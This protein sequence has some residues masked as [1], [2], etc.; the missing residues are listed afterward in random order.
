MREKNSRKLGS[1]ADEEKSASITLSYLVLYQA[2][3][4]IFGAAGKGLA[5]WRISD[6]KNYEQ[7]RKEESV[8]SRIPHA[9]HRAM[10]ALVRLHFRASGEVQHV[11]PEVSA[12]TIDEALLQRVQT[13][14]VDFHAAREGLL[15]R[16]AGEG[17]C[18]YEKPTQ[19][20]KRGSVCT[21][22]RRE[23]EPVDRQ[24]T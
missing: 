23:F 16:E 24:P 13:R 4:A 22:R 1:E 21:L 10:M 7:R 2:D 9:M 17:E 8:M 20:R 18:N 14:P 6:G 3:S 19:Q 5:I 11:I 15:D 12:A